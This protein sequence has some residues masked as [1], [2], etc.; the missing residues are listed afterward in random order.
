MCVLCVLVKLLIPA[1]LP[2]RKEGR[3]ATVSARSDVKLLKL[4]REPR[5]RRERGQ[6]TSHGAWRWD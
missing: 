1:V 3:A 5:A 2:R 6:W 4:S